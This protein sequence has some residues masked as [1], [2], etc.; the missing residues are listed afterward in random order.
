MFTCFL[1]HALLQ[2]VKY[3]ACVDLFHSSGCCAETY[4]PPEQPKGD[5]SSSMSAKDQLTLDD[6]I[7]PY[8]D[9]SDS[10]ED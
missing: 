9:D 3:C 10:D 4:K 1:P 5:E 6:Y 8:V 2:C 7:L